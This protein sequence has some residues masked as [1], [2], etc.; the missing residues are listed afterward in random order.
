MQSLVRELFQ[1]PQIVLE[2]QPDVV[3]LISEHRDAFDADTPGKSGKALGVVA[4]RLEHRRVHHSASENFEPAGF[5][6]ERASG[7]VT[8]PAT[9][10]DFR[11]RLRVRKKAR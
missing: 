7:A 4:N 3:H 9:D 6:A 5:L 10:V 2:E 1:E 8:G 11:A